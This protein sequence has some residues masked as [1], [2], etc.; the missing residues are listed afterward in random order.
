MKL[1]IDRIASPLGEIILVADE[2]SL[3]ALDFVEYESRLMSFLGK[4]YD[5]LELVEVKDPQGFSTKLSDYFDGDFD[6]LNEI[7]VDGGGTDFQQ[8]VWRELRKIPT[9][10]TLSYKELATKIDKP[11]AARAVGTANSLNPVMIAV[12]CHRVIAANGKLAGYA[13]GLERKQWLL[14]HE[15]REFSA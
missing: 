4:R 15:G 1:S 3:C 11:T 10:K 9:G 14:R 12:P 13:G 7:E 8:L 6:I 2:K 5:C